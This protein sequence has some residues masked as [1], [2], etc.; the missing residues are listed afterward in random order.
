[1][2]KS[3]PWI[4]M[5]ACVDSTRKGVQGLNGQYMESIRL[6]G[7]APLVIP[8]LENPEVLRSLV[9][10]L[11]GILLTGSDSDVDPGRYGA[12]KEKECG[13]VQPLRDGTDFF[14][15]DVACQRKIP[16][17]SICFGMQ[18]L[19]VYRGGSLIQHIPSR[20][21][22]SIKHSNAQTRGGPAH[23]VSFPGGSVLAD[24]AGS[25]AADVNSTHH[26]AVERLGCGLEVISTAPDGV[27]EAVLGVDPDHWILGV[28]WH[29]EKNYSYDPLSRGIFDRFIH[30]S[31][32]G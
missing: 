2:G 21:R 27:I 5:P 30:Q 9:E 12:E 13:Q 29:P 17:L 18:S 28:Q 15:L 4:G 25:L 23:P 24:I 26:Q 6:S 3:V 31:R 16:V 10:S 20:I 14:L 1:M 7:G 19:N 32:I 11:D 8:L 22:T